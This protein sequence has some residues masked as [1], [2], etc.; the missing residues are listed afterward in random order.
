M[1]VTPSDRLNFQ[2]NLADM[3][4]NSR[5]VVVL[6]PTLTAKTQ[7]S[8]DVDTQAGTDTM[9]GDGTGRTATWKTYEMQAF[10][11]T[12]NDVLITFGTV[13]PGVEQGDVVMV[14]RMQDREAILEAYGNKYHYIYADGSTFRI[15][16]LLYSGIGQREEV[17]VGC[18]HFSPST[19]RCAGY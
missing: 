2:G 4:H 8:Y 9:S 19:F 5:R 12:V 1:N 6:V 18:K 3:A 17:V 15:V 16:T 13:P 10:L 7:Y 14:A 11:L